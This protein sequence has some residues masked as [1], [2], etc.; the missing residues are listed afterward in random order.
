MR[1]N[2]KG[3]VGRCVARM[4]VAVL[5]VLFASPSA[6]AQIS[7]TDKDTYGNNFHVAFPANGSVGATQIFLFFVGTGA[8]NV[9]VSLASAP[10]FPWTQNFNLVAGQVYTLQLPSLPIPPAPIV[11]N[12][13]ESADIQVPNA[14]VN[15]GVV[16]TSTGAP[17]TVYGVTNT[18]P[19]QTAET[20]LALPDDV[21][22]ENYIVSSYTGVAT[23]FSELVVVATEADTVVDV[24]PPGGALFSTPAMAAGQAYM[25]QSSGDLTGTILRGR[26]PLDTLA[27]PIAAFGGNQCGFV[28]VGTGACDMLLEQL[29]PTETWGQESITVPFAMR[30]GG[31]IVRVMAAEADTDVTIDDGTGIININLPNIGSFAEALIQNTAV[32]TSIDAG[33]PILVTQFQRSALA[34]SAAFP[35]PLDFLRDPSMTIVPPHVQYLSEYTFATPPAGF[36]DYNFINLVAP[37]ASVSPT[38]DPDFLL[39]GE[40]VSSANFNFIDDVGNT[41]PIVWTQIGTSSF[42]GARVKIE[43]QPGADPTVHTIVAPFP[44][45]LILYGN[46]F[47]TTYA[48][49]GGMRLS[50]VGAVSEIVITV[51]GGVQRAGF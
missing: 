50:Q 28:P 23:V 35:P 48:N 17:F 6:Q 11:Y 15:K 40:V 43:L 26:D 22:S 45:G 24:T 5:L 27:K 16:V 36:D 9:T 49:P 39:D 13:A 20:F 44:F 2:C 14:V 10:P 21:L 8:S 47:I 25:V 18:L 51:T 31:D 34:D 46:G 3:V 33:K 32:I 4:L 41:L 30:S 38:V 7:L 1:S 12:A 37:T 19:N 29:T 42:S